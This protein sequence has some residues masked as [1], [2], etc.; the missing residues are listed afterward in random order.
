M[1]LGK[2]FWE[3]YNFLQ[4]SQWWSREKLEEYQMDQLTKLLNHAY[5]NV[6]YYRRVFDERSLKPK[7]IQDF[8]D[9]QMLPYLT[10][11]IIQNN[12]LDLVARN[13]PKSKLQYV[14]TGGSTGV[15]LG[16]YNEKGVSDVKEWAFM[17]AQWNRVGFKIGDRCVV[18]RGNITESASR[19]KFWKYDPVNKNLILSSFH[20]TEENM[21]RYIQ[22]IREFKPKFIQ[23]YPS[24][25]TIL[26]RFMKEGD[27]K[28]FPTVRALLCGSENLYSWQR[29]LLEE[30]FQ[31]RVYSWY[32]H[33]EMAA[34][35]GECEKNTYYH[36]FPEYGIVELIDKDG[37]PVTGEN[38]IGEIVATGFNNFAMPF[39]RYRTMDLAVPSNAKCECGRSYPLLKRVEGRLQELVVMKDKRLISL[40]ALIFAQHFE[41]F[42]RMKEMQLIQEKE[43]EL[44]VRIVKTAQYLDSDEHEILSKMQRAVGSGLDINFDYVGY[45]PRTQSGKYRFLIQRLPIEFEDITN[46][47]E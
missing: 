43:G 35:A 12:L 33:T 23:A 40:T 30:V 6:P 42:S 19:G 14:T 46:K 41:A 21:P 5:D 10:K 11:E 2:V 44:T 3:T 15:P 39:I 36:I 8:K 17:L 34:L 29:E 37:N 31:C 32:G 24:A 7:D 26:A 1:R 13:Y 22:K 18:L 20:L 38:E 9:L 28:P 45:I 4:E 25:I 16:F 47:E 27:V